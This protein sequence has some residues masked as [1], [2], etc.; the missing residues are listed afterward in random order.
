M[1]ATCEG[2]TSYLKSPTPR[3]ETLVFHEAIHPVMKPV[4]LTATT[5]VV[6]TNDVMREYVIFG[7]RPWLSN[8]ETSLPVSKRHFQIK[9]LHFRSITEI[10]K[11]ENVTFWSENLVCWTGSDAFPRAV[12]SGSKTSVDE[13]VWRSPIWR[14]SLFENL[15][16]YMGFEVFPCDV[17]SSGKTKS[18][19]IPKWIYRTMQIVQIANGCVLL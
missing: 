3:P 14:H 16:N 1:L 15:D 17:T 10:F 8:S 12:T 19:G 5:K 4:N 9:K 2:R 13:M 11:Y 18:F 7:Q 6:V